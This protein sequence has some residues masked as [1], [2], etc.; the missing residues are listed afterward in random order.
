M[1]S[2]YRSINISKQAFHQKLDRLQSVKSEQGLLLLLIYQIREDHLPMGIR[3][4]TTNELRTQY[5]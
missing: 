4:Y 1:N 5:K 3:G 2:L